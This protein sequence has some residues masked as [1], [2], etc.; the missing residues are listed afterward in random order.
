M[1]SATAGGNLTMLLHDERDSV[2]RADFQEG[3]IVGNL[4]IGVLA[5]AMDVLALTCLQPSHIPSLS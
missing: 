1:S 4:V 3:R 5:I 2:W